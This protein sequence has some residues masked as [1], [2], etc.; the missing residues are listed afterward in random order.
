VANSITITGDKHNSRYFELVCTQKS[1]GSAKNSSTITWTLYA[2]GDST[3]YSTGPTT[4]VIN[5][6]TVYSKERTSWETGKFPVAQG[7]VSGATE[8]AHNADG[9]KTIAV[10]F[11]TAIYY[12]DV[13]EYSA[14]WTLDSIQRY[15]SAMH[16]IYIEEETSVTMN[17]ASNSKI[18]KLWYST[19]NG[20][21]WTWIADPHATSG[22]YTITDLE[23]YHAYPIKT[24]VER[25]D[26]GLRT[27]SPVIYVNT[28]DFPHCIEAPDFVIGNPVTLK[29]YNPL[30]RSL[31]FQITANGTTLSYLWGADGTTY[32]GI[33]AENVQTALY[34][35][36]PDSYE[37]K[38]TVTVTYGDSVR[39][40]D[41]GGKYSIDQA[42]CYPIAGS[43]DY[44]DARNVY[45]VD[46]VIVETLS[47]VY[48]K[49]S[50]SQ[51]ATPVNGAS[52][53]KLLVA[54]GSA[55]KMV[56]YSSDEILVELGS[57]NFSSDSRIMFIRTFDSRGLS[58][59]VSKDVEIIKYSKPIVNIDAQR[60]NNFEAQTTIRVGGN[61]SSFGSAGTERN[62]IKS[63]IMRIRESGGSWS[64]PSTLVVTHSA[65]S[66]TCQ[67]VIL[68][69]DNEKS[70]E[71]EVKVTDL[72][73]SV[74]TEYAT[75]DV[76]KAVFF[77]SSNKKACYVNGT[78]II[79][80][81]VVD[82][83][84]GW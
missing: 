30:K 16:S 31:K 61:Y 67:D 49:I 19:D 68:S 23:P 29:F 26:N 41:G 58:C 69:L 48:V 81:D 28:K 65:G 27:V 53:E 5:G 36:I 45:G 20:E 25:E 18:A 55:Y 34:N 3:H 83:W 63:A 78:K 43:F 9:T 35:T 37:G 24:R 77:I 60:L 1:N 39:T 51:M 4:V 71:I 8:V 14:N 33:Y 72:Y 22:R 38:Y 50:P 76:G 21:T 73:D 2:K 40:F 82:T 13:K 6:K 59:L 70:F 64:S 54:F 17:W 80:Y 11:S 44:Y 74:T 42:K 66:Y 79:M 7:S 84:G 12:K 57:V 15:A 52:I 32:T 47:K 46:H 75:I 10:K 56:P 62:G